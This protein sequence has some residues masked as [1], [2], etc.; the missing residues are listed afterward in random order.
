MGQLSRGRVHLNSPPY[1]TRTFRIWIL[2]LVAL[3]A[4]SFFGMRRGMGRASQMNAQTSADSS[5]AQLKV[6]EEAKLVLEVTEVVGSA[7]I[8]GH[9]LEKKTEAIY[10][11]TSKTIK[12]AFNA[13]TPIVMGKA[14]DLHRG[15]VIHI[16]ATM[17]SDRQL[18][19]QQLVNLTG[20]VQV[21]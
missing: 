3:A 10:L 7:T 18:H 5:L 12:V 11:R 2:F 13:A 17:G 14:Q 6:G 21:Q 19:A 15:A 9:L 4:L 16:T 1:S 8:E 20:Y